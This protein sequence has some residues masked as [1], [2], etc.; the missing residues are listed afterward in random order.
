[1]S[2]WGK[3]WGGTWGLVW[4]SIDVTPVPPIMPA[5]FYTLIGPA[6][7]KYEL[8]GPNAGYTILVGTSLSQY[9]LEA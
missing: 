5:R 9:V 1:M 8:S 3:V 7:T 4:G 2:V 6:L